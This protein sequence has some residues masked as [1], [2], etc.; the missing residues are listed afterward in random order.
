MP[1]R[2]NR[3]RRM[4]PLQID[5]PP[6]ERDSILDRLASALAARRLE[7]PAILALELHKPLA[8]LGSQALIVFTPLLAPAI[9]LERMQKA[10]RLLERPENIERLIVRIEALVE[11]RD[12]G[13]APAEGA[14]RPGGSG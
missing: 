7:V 13:S 1:R 9:G 6:E 10:S 11:E 5:L 3:K 4:Q 2:N 14:R 12:R 8:F